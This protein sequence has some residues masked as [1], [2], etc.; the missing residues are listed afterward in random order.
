MLCNTAKSTHK[1]YK[2]SHQT[3]TQITLSSTNSSNSRKYITYN[4]QEYSSKFSFDDNIDSK[5]ANRPEVQSFNSLQ[6][7]EKI[8]KQANL[9]A[10]MTLHSTKCTE[11][12]SGYARNQ[13]NFS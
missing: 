5:R 4:K 13:Q 1:N 7:Q 2:A 3:T 11:S 8:R 10:T 12:I 6:I 9:K